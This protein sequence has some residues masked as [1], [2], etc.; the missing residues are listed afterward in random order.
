MSEKRTALHELPK[1]CAHILDSVKDSGV[2]LKIA[3]SSIPNAGS[4][5]FVVN[6]VAAG[7]EIF[8]SQPLLMICEGNTTNICDYCFRDQ[9]SSLHPDGW[10]VSENDPDN[11]MMAACIR[12]KLVQYCS[13][14]RLSFLY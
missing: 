12:C 4:G 3:A 7:S 9:N 11:V 8:R 10:F 6:D 1:V 2:P 13:K 5:L 14:V